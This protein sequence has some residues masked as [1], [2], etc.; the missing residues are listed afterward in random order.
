MNIQQNVSL[1][2][3]NTFGIDVAAK[4]YVSIT[5]IEELKEVLETEKDIFVLSGG[6]NLAAHTSY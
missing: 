1:K 5:S 4:R 6:S 3:F 2:P